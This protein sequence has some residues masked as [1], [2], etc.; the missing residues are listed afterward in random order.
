VSEIH[1]QVTDGVQRKDAVSSDD[2]LSLCHFAQVADAGAVK[3]TAAVCCDDDVMNDVQCTGH[4][5]LAPAVVDGGCTRFK[6]V[7]ELYFVLQGKDGVLKVVPKGPKH[8]V[9]FVVDNTCNVQR[10]AAGQKNQFWDDCGVW[11]SKHSHV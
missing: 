10:H 6:N 8:N 9:C 5:P 11:S 2:D 1:V 7:S 3:C 4:E